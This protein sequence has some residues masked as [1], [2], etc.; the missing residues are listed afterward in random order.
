MSQKISEFGAM[1][2]LEGMRKVYYLNRIVAE[3]EAA[4]DAGRTHLETR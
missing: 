2:L 1:A 4:R 3:I